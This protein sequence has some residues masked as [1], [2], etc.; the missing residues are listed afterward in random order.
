MLLHNFLLS[1][2]GAGIGGIDCKAR[3]RLDALRRARLCSH[4]SP[5]LVTAIVVTGRIHEAEPGFYHTQ[6]KPK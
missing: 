5:A 3:K 6:K 2:Q 4:H 1:Q